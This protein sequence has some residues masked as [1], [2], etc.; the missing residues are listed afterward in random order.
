MFLSKRSNGYFYLHYKDANGILQKV[1][2]QTRLKAEANIFFRNFRSTQLKDRKN[3]TNPTI[4][5]F[6]QQYS[7]SIKQILSPRTQHLHM[8]SL[9]RLQNLLGG[10]FRLRQITPFEI[11]K[12]K[13]SLLTTLS[14]VT[15]NIRLK[16]LRCILS[17][18]VRWKILESNPAK[19]V[20]FVPENEKAPKHISV[21]EINRLLESVK[22]LWLRQIFAFAVTTGLRRSEITN[23]KWD[24]I[25]LD[26]RIIV[27]ASTSTFKVKAGKTRIVPLSD[28][29]MQI[30]Q[31]RLL[32][33]DNSDFVF[34]SNGKAVH[35][36]YLT[37]RFKYYV[38][39]AG[40]K[41][42]YNFHSLRSSFASLL[43]LNGSDIYKVS[44][45]LGHSR[46]TT[47]QQFYAHL[48]T[49][50][51]HETVNKIQIQLNE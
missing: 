43:I 42:D 48:D 27:I 34:T 40:L 7:N 9:N 15:V 1:S 20:S 8:L 14:P 22:E 3:K 6:V 41:D 50:H 10:E 51:L 47:T 44:K 13:S 21:V 38:R 49:E 37:T 28:I 36:N 30:I 2:S 29:A 24:Q 35:E 31:S 4:E 11:E 23:M 16:K 25:D 12:L 5:Q 18:A 26:R 19:E 17:T 46:V 33:K 32:L 39:K 45:L